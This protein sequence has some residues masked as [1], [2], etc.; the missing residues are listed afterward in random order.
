MNTG[1]LQR[2]Q[3]SGCIFTI[4]WWPKYV[5]KKEMCLKWMLKYPQLY[6]LFYFFKC[7]VLGMLTSLTTS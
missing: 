3:S 7:V 1:I 2:G 5:H 4:H 6:S